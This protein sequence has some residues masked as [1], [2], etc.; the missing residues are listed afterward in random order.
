MSCHPRSLRLNIREKNMAH[1]LCPICE[2]AVSQDADF[3]PECG[4]EIDRSEGELI[5]GNPK[6]LEREAVLKQQQLLRYRKLYEHTRQIG[7]LQQ[8]M[9]QKLQRMW[10]WL[11]LL[12]VVSAALVIGVFLQWRELSSTASIRNHAIEQQLA[13]LSNQIEQGLLRSSHLQAIEKQ[14]DALS[15]KVQQEMSHRQELEK[16]LASFLNEAAQKTAAFSGT[17][18]QSIVL[19]ST[20]MTISHDNAKSEFGLDDNWLPLRYIE[21]DFEAQGKAIIDHATGLMWQQSGSEAALTYE[22]AREYTIPNCSRN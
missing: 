5:I 22:K 19:R 11:G 18:A 12:L 8:E 17:R 2:T 20:P 16:Q 15:N 3:C 13:S 1:S 14:L 10:L 9:S 7:T 21:N 4:W 6:E